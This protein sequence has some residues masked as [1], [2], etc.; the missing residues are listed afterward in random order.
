M[1][2]QWTER[3]SCHF[4]SFIFII[5]SRQCLRHQWLPWHPG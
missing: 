2:K 1:T 5:L 3:Y 4:R